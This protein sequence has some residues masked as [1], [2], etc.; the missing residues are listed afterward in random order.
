M[1]RIKFIEKKLNEAPSIFKKNI[2]NKIILD[3][4]N[5]NIDRL[6]TIDIEKVL[7]FD[8]AKQSI[9]EQ[10]K[11]EKKTFVN[12]KKFNS[13]IIG[14]EIHKFA[15][16]LNKLALKGEKQ[17]NTPQCT[18]FEQIKEYLINNISIIKLKELT[19]K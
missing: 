16:E 19:I 11:Q 12:S 7:K 9:L 10:E 2:T 14:I 13:L 17:I 4:Y 3:E 5:K 6:N 8:F 18:N 15:P 1:N